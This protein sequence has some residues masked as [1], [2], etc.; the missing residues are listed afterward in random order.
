MDE[1]NAEAV[2]EALGGE[3]WQSGGNIWLVVLRRADGKL[4]VLSDDV[5]C[6]YNND[7]AFENNSPALSILLH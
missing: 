4:V 2:A 3:T 5:I 6:E 1:K 7:E